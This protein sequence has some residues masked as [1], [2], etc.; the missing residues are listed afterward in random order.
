MRNALGAGLLAA[1]SL[2]VPARA[3]AG[4]TDKAA[5]K[6]KVT[7]SVSVLDRYNPTAGGIIG[8]TVKAVD[9]G[10]IIAEGLTNANG[11]AVVPVDVEPT[12]SLLFKTTVNFREASKTEAPPEKG[13]KNNSK[14][15]LTLSLQKDVIQ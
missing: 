7:F 2:A 4:D 8:A 5:D 3:G 9:N 14:V 6:V 13:W 10:I 15:S 11:L 12:H 1:L